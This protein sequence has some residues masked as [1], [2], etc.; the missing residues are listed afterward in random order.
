MT[1]TKIIILGTG[2]SSTILSTIL[3]KHG[4]E[5]IL[6]D[7]TCHP[8]FA[9]GESTIPQTS[10]LFRLLALRY[11]IPEFEHL[12]SFRRCKEI[13]QNCG[14]KRNFGFVYHKEGIENPVSYNQTPLPHDEIHLFRQDTDAYLLH[15]AIHYGAKVYQNC[16]IKDLEIN[17]SEVIL[18]TSHGIFHGN[19]I[20]DGTGYGS[21]IAGMR[22]LREVPTRLKAHSRS[23]FTHMIDV[24][25]FDECLD[26]EKN[27]SMP[28]PLYQGTLH[29]IFKEG[30]LWVIPFNNYDGAIN[31]L[32]SVGL[33]LDPRII[34][35]PNDI[36]PEE[37][38]FSFIKKYPAIE[39]QF[40]NA[41]SVREWVST[42]RLQYS[43]KSSVGERFFLMSH[44]SGF[45]DPLFS[46]GICNTL[47][48]VNLLASALIKA[49]KQN[50]YCGPEFEK[51]EQ[52]QQGVI[53]FNDDLVNS[54][55][56]S[57]RDP[58]LWNCFWRI[59]GLI[60]LYGTFRVTRCN[61]KY[62]VSGDDSIFN[63]LL[64]TKY[65]GAITSNA[66][67]W[68]L[69]NDAVSIMS[70]VE[71]GQLTNEEAIKRF[72]L[73]FREHDKLAPSIFPFSDLSRKWTKP[74]VS[75]NLK[76]LQ[77]AKSGAPQ[78]VRDEYFDYNTLLLSKLSD[79]K[80]ANIFNHE[81]FKFVLGA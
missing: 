26:K 46:R 71:T 76:L 8:R 59:W 7:K 62:E 10:A 57:F 73:L 43:S 12:S 54:S 19:Y 56:I 5:N 45:L 78:S 75:E 47:E 36:S 13:T 16:S 50:D 79:S 55:Y 40:R 34:E 35:K 72:Q 21:Q 4:V 44:A 17:A 27:P 53:D 29:H 61:L 80:L 11:N 24:M 15:L 25:H 23:V 20:V 81:Y 9:I 67:V 37:E 48:V 33:Q 32:C 1:S 41:K 52:F 18:K 60:A 3:S 31:P 28:I 2:I 6:I 22:D 64:D 65:P 51:I 66:D 69:L 68:N 39:R 49:D 58:A 30:W 42:S 74:T 14:I 38:F 63:D 77:W 70:K